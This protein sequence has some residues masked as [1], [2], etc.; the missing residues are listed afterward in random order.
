M[1]LASPRYADDPTLAL[2]PMSFMSVDDASF[3]PEVA[4]EHTVAE[5]RRTY[6]ELLSGSNWLRRIRLRR[7]H[8]IIELFA[9]TRDTPKHHLV[10]VNYAM[11][12]RVL[13]EGEKLVENGRL[14][15]AEHVFDLTFD[16]LENAEDDASLDLR[17]LREERTRFLNVLKAQV[18][19]FPQIIDSRGRIL[20]PPA[21]EEKPG[22]M[23]GMA[24][25]PGVVSGPVKVLHDPHEKPVDKG[26]VL[27]AYTTDPGWT[28]LFV[29]ASAVLLEVGGI[30]QHGAVVA[31][32]YGKPCV[33]GI[34]GLMRKLADG[35]MVEVDGT[36]GIVR[37][38]PSAPVA[39]SEA[40]DE[41]VG[42]ADG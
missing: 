7:I 30:L 36:A 20:R 32:E 18:R 10:I 1:D 24:V 15:A 2:R 6:E 34:D 19:E 8:R 4:H 28:P 22:E 42:P 33:A 5:R 14:D 3:D 29:P 26:D 11:R 40:A 21:R 41:I 31:R 17:R 9:G 39:T 25:S 12:K 27:V 35:Q 16:D 38:L 13:M 23:S 37:T